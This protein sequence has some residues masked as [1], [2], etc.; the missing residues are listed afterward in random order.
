[1][2][3][4]APWIWGNSDHE[5][6]IDRIQRLVSNF[7]PKKNIFFCKN[8]VFWNQE[9]SSLAIK[10]QRLPIATC[11]LELKIYIP[12]QNH[13]NFILFNQKGVVSMTSLPLLISILI[14][15]NVSNLYLRLNFDTVL[16]DLGHGPIRIVYQIRWSK[17]LH[18]D[19]QI[20]M[21]DEFQ[22]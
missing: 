10:I 7:S 15:T 20:S 3:R 14:P 9:K 5:W 6:P 22:S 18:L 21:G 17:K 19:V 16:M 11:C 4:F 12:I 2:D 1:M 13:I 8:S